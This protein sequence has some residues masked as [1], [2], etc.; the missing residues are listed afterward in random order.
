MYFYLPN[1]NFYLLVANKKNV[2]VVV[3]VD[4]DD[5]MMMKLLAKTFTIAKLEKFIFNNSK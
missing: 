2:V 4:D 3:V 1:S 5:D